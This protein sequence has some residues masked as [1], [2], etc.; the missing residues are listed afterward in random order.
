ME[1]KKIT[2]IISTLLIASIFGLFILFETDST[3]WPSQQPDLDTSDT[4]LQTFNSEEEFQRYLTEAST[5]SRSQGAVDRASGTEELDAAPD[6]DYAVEEDESATEHSEQEIDQDS[7]VEPDNIVYDDEAIYQSHNWPDHMHAVEELPELELKHNKSSVSG[8][9]I[10]KED[11]LLTVG[12]D[13][14]ELLDRDSLSVEWDKSVDSRIIDVRKSGE[15]LILLTRESVNM[16]SPCPVN[17][18]EDVELGC[19]DMVYPSSGYESDFTYHLTRL[20]IDSGEDLESTGFVG[21][22]NT[23]IVVTDNSTFV[24]YTDS[25]PESEIIIEFLLNEASADSELRDRIEEIQS[26][27]LTERSV[28]NEV[29][30][31]MDRFE[32]RVGEE[33]AE[34]IMEEF[35]D[36]DRENMRDYDTTFL[37][38]FNNQEFEEVGTLELEGQISNLKATDDGLVAEN[39]IDGLDFENSETDLQKIQNNE[40]V[41]VRKGFEDSIR[42]IETLG[43]D[44][45]LETFEELKLVDSETLETRE[46]IEQN[47]LSFTT[48]QDNLFATVIGEEVEERSSNRELKAFNQEF[49]QVADTRLERFGYNLENQHTEFNEQVVFVNEIRDEDSEFVIFDQEEG[50]DSVE[51]GNELSGNLIS[52]ED[53]L[54]VVSSS[55]VQSF[56]EEFEEVSS[57]ELITGNYRDEPVVQPEPVP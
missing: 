29:E 17:P 21:S 27:E 12:S 39:S 6:Q 32:E 9:L 1:T 14:I 36:W 23:E 37:T 22:R 10:L 8:D 20:D 54:Y 52:I 38:Q 28:Q 48:T 49:E 33:E 34:S 46:T 5:E 57:I 53:H 19:S 44:L 15:N 4:Q 2:A 51:S 50:F 40:I 41:E 43:D 13:S 35:K 24:G 7:V 11:H 16:D 18:L 56:D 30:H 47:T 31:A 45:I 3:P 25:Q 42:S 55:Q 26:Y